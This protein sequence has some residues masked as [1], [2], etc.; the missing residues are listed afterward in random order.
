M[1]R[2]SCTRDPTVVPLLKKFLVH[3]ESVLA[4]IRHMVEGKVTTDV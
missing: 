2:P 1:Q 3:K 4:C